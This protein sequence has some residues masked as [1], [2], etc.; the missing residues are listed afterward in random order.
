VKS[1]DAVKQISDDSEIR[2]EYGEIVSCQNRS[3]VNGDIS[4]TDGRGSGKIYTDVVISYWVRLASGLE[5]EFVL[6]A[7]FFSARKGHKV[8]IVYFNFRDVALINCSS[9]DY[10]YLYLGQPPTRNI[11]W[12]FAL[13]AIIGMVLKDAFEIPFFVV[14]FIGVVIYWLVLVNLERRSLKAQRMKIINAV[15]PTILLLKSATVVS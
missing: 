12:S 8:A 7:K 11:L 13:P 10:C 4:I 3:E 1:S 14:W 9:G 2:Y 6:D 15:R 5:R